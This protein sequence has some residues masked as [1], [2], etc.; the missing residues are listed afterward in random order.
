M[1]SNQHK[2]P[3]SHA[4]P[5]G[6]VRLNH[7]VAAALCRPKRIGIVPSQCDRSFVAEPLSFR[8]AAVG[9]EP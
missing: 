6:S 1:T 2:R 4:Q 3:G 9:D 7:Q 8:S 5:D